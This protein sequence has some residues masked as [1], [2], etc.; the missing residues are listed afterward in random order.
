MSSAIEI[1]QLLEA[2]AVLLRE[3]VM[4]TLQGELAFAT[5]VSVNALE[6]AVRELRQPDD[7]KEAH[8]SRLVEL[9]GMDGS[10]DELEQRLCTAIRA[11]SLDES[12]AQLVRHLRLS[13]IA[14]LEVDQPRYSALRRKP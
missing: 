3:R 7:V 10:V 9:L 5:R 12:S 14:S 1:D 8:R 4:P 13:A 2:V 6:L 11:G